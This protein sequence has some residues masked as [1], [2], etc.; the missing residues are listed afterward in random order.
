M[1]REIMKVKEIAE[2]LGFSP[3]KVYRL[4]ETSKIPAIKVGKQYR[5]KKSII[6]DWLVE[7]LITKE[8]NPG[9]K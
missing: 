6:D 9:K 7:N 2:Y 4:I 8:S 1:P 3:T 5:F